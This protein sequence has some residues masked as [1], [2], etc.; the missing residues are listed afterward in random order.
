VRVQGKYNDGTTFT[1]EFNTVIFAIG[2]DACTSNIGLD[3][4]ICRI[5][6]LKTDIVSR[7]AST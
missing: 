4:V 2:R 6:M 1:D 5:V 7:L 3:Q